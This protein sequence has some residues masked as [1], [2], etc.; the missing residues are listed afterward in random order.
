MAVTKPLTVRQPCLPTLRVQ[1]QKHVAVYGNVTSLYILPIH[2]QA[3]AAIEPWHWQPGAGWLI[4]VIRAPAIEGL[5]TLSAH[6][7]HTICVFY[8]EESAQQALAVLLDATKG[9]RP[10]YVDLREL[11][12]AGREERC[13]WV[14]AEMERRTQAYVKSRRSGDAPAVSRERVITLD[15]PETPAEVPLLDR[16]RDQPMGIPLIGWLD[17]SGYDN[18]PEPPAPGEILRGRRGADVFSRTA[19]LT[20]MGDSFVEEQARMLAEQQ[21]AQEQLAAQQDAMFAAQLAAN[22]AIHTGPVADRGLGGGAPGGNPAAMGPGQRLRER[23]ASITGET[24]PAAVERS[25]GEF[26]GA[27]TSA[28]SHLAAAAAGGAVTASDARLARDVRSAHDRPTISGDVVSRTHQRYETLRRAAAMESAREAAVSELAST[29]R[30]PSYDLTIAMVAEVLLAAGYRRG[31]LN[32]R[33]ESDDPHILLLNSVL[34]QL[35]EVGL[36]GVRQYVSEWQRDNEDYG[37]AP[38]QVRVGPTIAEL[39]SITDREWP[40][41]PDLLGAVAGW[42]QMSGHPRDSPG[43]T[44]SDEVLALVNVAL[45]R[46]GMLSA[47]LFD[48]LRRQFGSRDVEP[49]LP[50]GTVVGG[51]ASVFNAL[52]LNNA[53]RLI[54]VNLLGL[55]GLRLDDIRDA[56]VRLA[57]P[58]PLHAIRILESLAMRVPATMAD[59]AHMANYVALVL[60][61]SGLSATLVGLCQADRQNNGDATDACARLLD[62]ATPA[63]RDHILRAMEQNE[64]ISADIATLAEGT[65][66]GRSDHLP[67]P[68][69]YG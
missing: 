44:L 36:N 45:T 52:G 10:C 65:A 69:M 7:P 58:L 42:L 6:N 17:R 47:G 39:R 25:V 68:G 33:G 53:T 28:E 13:K 54:V 41:N 43:P 24:A 21:I 2:C 57:R 56:H 37:A 18:A 31:H 27:F 14:I 20:N 3:L 61:G 49:A 55:P 60:S 22:A 11:E 40:T 26:L 30:D 46:V 16:F 50:P 51:M 15:V 34:N 29:L 8:N 32:L 4:S 62:L 59:I 35:G 9:S 64:Q 67:D 19:P 5:D 1:T 48:L 38:L 23:L 63:V 12:I 66:M